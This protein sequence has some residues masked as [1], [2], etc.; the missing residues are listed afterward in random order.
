MEISFFGVEYLIFLRETLY[1]RTDSG[2]YI[3]YK[4]ESVLFSLMDYNDYLMINPLFSAKVSRD[5]SPHFGFP[6]NYFCSKRVGV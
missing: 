1:K 3:L 5:F 4:Q 6:L 2:F